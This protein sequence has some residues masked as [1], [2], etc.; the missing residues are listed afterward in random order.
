MSYQHSLSHLLYG[1]L[2]K[3]SPETI[4]GNLKM[5][6][7]NEYKLLLLCARTRITEEIERE[8]IT[9]IKQNIDWDYLLRIAANHRLTSLLYWQ[10][11]SVTPDSVPPEILK[12]LKTHFNGNVHKNLLFMGELQR[13]LSIFGFHEIKAIPYKGPVLA[14]QAYGNLAFR[15][16]GDLDIF[17]DRKD[18][19]KVKEILSTLGYEPKLKLSKKRELKYLKFQ[20]EYQF[21]NKKTGISLEIQWNLADISLSF[22]NEPIFT[23]DQINTKLI[24]F[25]NKKLP[26]FSY[27]DL[28]IILSLHT[29]THLWSKLSWICDIAELV[30][31]SEKLD[32]NK[33]IDKSHY[34]AV[35]R[36][37]YLNLSL[38]N[39]LFDVKLPK[40]IMDKIGSDKQIECLKL[41][42]KRIT[43]DRKDHSFG[44]SFILRFKIREKLQ[45]KLKDFLKI[46]IVPT[47]TEWKMFQKPLHLKILYIL[48]RL[49]QLFNKIRNN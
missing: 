4:L 48:T 9:L 42:I 2:N 41:D 34:L 25:N 38:V 21:K 43:I 11:N 49:K 26:V 7:S 13:I 14:I 44:K 15:E 45:N 17:I 5:D 31:N 27:E 24:E 33:V 30:K 40:D 23:M 22:P 1:H 35:E 10:L 39:E 46:I 12:W 32:W 16:F 3:I 19:F 6:L 18:V 8:I 20:R 28:L 36:I 47:S 29:V 37:V